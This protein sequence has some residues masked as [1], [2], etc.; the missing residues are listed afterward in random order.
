MNIEEKEKGQISDLI[1]IKIRTID[2]E[3]QIKIN[4]NE[5]IKD[6]KEKIENV[7]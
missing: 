3:F 2:N 5:K 1:T 4:H 7:K 6:L